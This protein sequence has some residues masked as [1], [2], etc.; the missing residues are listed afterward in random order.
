MIKGAHVVDTSMPVTAPGSVDARLA[1][2]RVLFERGQVAQ[3]EA[4]LCEPAARVPAREDVAMLL[5]EVLRSQGR[6]SAAFEVMATLAEP[7]GFEAASRCARWRSRAMRATTSWRRGFATAHWCAAGR[8]PN[9]WWW[10][11]TGRAKRANL[12]LHTSAIAQPWPPASTWIGRTC[13]ER[14]RIPNTTRILSTPIVCVARRGFVVP[15]SHP[16]RVS[17]SAMHSPRF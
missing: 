3:A 10:R 1:T 17:R 8:C 13:W 9:R 14:C 2:A 15:R 7:P 6:L 4:L 11:G 16:D 5:G 12:R